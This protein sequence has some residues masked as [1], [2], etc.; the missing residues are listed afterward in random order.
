MNYKN[1]SAEELNDRRLLAGNIVLDVRTPQ[2]IDEGTIP[3]NKQ[4]NFFSRSFK[5]E[6]QKLD[7]SKSY[8]VYCR[9]GNRSGKACAMMAEMGFE[10]LCNLKGGI[11]AWNAFS[12]KT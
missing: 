11:S 6:V 9:S 8:L 5:A 10:N 12:N 4:I 7:K 3:N 2:E 1:V